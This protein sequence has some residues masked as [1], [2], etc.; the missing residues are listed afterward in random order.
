[1]ATSALLTDP[2]LRQ[3]LLDRYADAVKEARRIGKEFADATP[4]EAALEEFATALE[5]AADHRVVYKDNLPVRTVARCPFTGLAV[6]YP[7]DDAGLDGPFWDF[8]SPVRAAGLRPGTCYGITGAMRLVG[9]FRYVPH[10]AIVGPSIPYVIP[11]LLEVEGSKA[12]LSSLPIGQHTGY[13]ITYFAPPGT[14]GEVPTTD[15]W[16][17]SRWLGVDEHG[18]SIWTSTYKL[19]QESDEA[20][21]DEDRDA[22]LEPWISAGRVGWVAPDDATATTHWEVTGCPYIGL[23]G[24]LDD[25]WVVGV[26]HT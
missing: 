19:Y 16:G 11:R 15:E 4:D 10:I 14:S 9:G 2:E 1:M 21:L 26:W 18:E 24:S 8:Q 3:A 7:I 5:T 12:V 23:D 22:D 13:V 20:P 17:T 6:L 25:Q